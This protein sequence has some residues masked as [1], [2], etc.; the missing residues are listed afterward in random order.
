MLYGEII[1]TLLLWSADFYITLIKLNIR[2]YNG[3]PPYT[4]RVWC[5]T[6]DSYKCKNC[7]NETKKSKLQKSFDVKN[8]ITFYQI[9]KPKAFDMLTE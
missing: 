3:Q 5:E 1:N 9:Y 6:N 8:I 7:Y 2:I 4:A